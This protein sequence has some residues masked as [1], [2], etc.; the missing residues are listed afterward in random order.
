MIYVVIAAVL[1]FALWQLV[2]FVKRTKAGSCASGCSGCGSDGNCS[3]QK[4]KMPPL[5]EE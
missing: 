1:G 4:T 3:I 5:K 2:S